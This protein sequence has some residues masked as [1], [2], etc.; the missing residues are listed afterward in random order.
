MSTV[1]RNSSN[2]T[3]NLIVRCSDVALEMFVSFTGQALFLF[4]GEMIPKLKS[5]QSKTSQA[6]SSSHQQG[7]ASK[8][9][10]GKKGKQAR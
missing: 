6:E 10:K 4:V 9:K 2:R 7:A 8:K 1:I 5:R 3:C